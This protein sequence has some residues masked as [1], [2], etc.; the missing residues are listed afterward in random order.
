MAR[1]LL[2][3]REESI[4]RSRGGQ[5]GYLAA[6]ARVELAERKS[7]RVICTRNLRAKRRRRGERRDRNCAKS[8][9]ATAAAAATR[10]LQRAARRYLNFIVLLA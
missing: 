1:R 5:V 4:R 7:V 9:A 2:T 8:V 6:G 3:R 10:N